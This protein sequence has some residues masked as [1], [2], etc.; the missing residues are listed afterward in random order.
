MPVPFNL[1]EW[2][3]FR[4]G[5]SLIEFSKSSGVVDLRQ[6]M[7]WNFAPSSFREQS[8]ASSIDRQHAARTNSILDV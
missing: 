8:P 6:G 7:F 2:V 5:D 3:P 1:P 4:N